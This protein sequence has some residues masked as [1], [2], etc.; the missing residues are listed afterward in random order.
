RELARE[1]VRVNGA[2]FSRLFIRVSPHFFT[3]FPAYPARNARLAR[4]L[5]DHYFGCS[6]LASTWDQEA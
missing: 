4:G 3:K 2:G 6:R 5:Q 1:V